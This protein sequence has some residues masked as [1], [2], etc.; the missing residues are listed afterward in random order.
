[1]ST[2]FFRRIGP[3]E[4][5]H[6]IGRGGMGHVFLAR[7]TRED[8]RVVALKV[9]PDGPDEEAGHR[10]A[11]ERQ[12]AELQRAFLQ[13]S[14]FVPR[15][16]EVDDADGYLYIAMEYVEGEDLSTVIRRGPME[17]RRAAAIAIQLCQFLEEIDRLDSST[18]ASPLTLLHNDL[19]P[20]NVRLTANDGVK[21]LD[22]GAAKSLTMSRR[23][24]RNDF[25]STPYL[26]PECLE[27]GDRDRQADAWAVGAILYEMVAGR[28]AF[29]ADST[30][31]L[32]DLI[33]SRT[34]PAAP[35]G[36]PTSLQA[37]IAKLLAPSPRDRYDGATAIREDLERFMSGLP[38]TAEEQ[39]GPQAEEDEPPTR[40]ISDSA[41]REN[42]EPA[43]RR[44]PRAAPSGAVTS[45]ATPPLPPEATTAPA[46][47]ERPG[48]A[49]SRRRWV[50][51]TLFFILLALVINEG[52]LSARAERLAATVPTQEFASLTTVWSEYDG[53]ARRSWFN[54]A[55]ARGLE[56]ALVDQTQ[57]LADRVIDSY[58]M[59]ASTVW[60]KQ[61]SEAEAA[62]LRATKAAPGDEH[63]R[64]TLRYVQGHLHRIDGETRKRERQDAQADRE[65]ARAVTAFREAARLRRNW[66]DPFL[67]LARAFIYG[68]GDMDRGADALRQ[69]ERL[70]HKLGPR[71]TAQLAY[72]YG[73]RGGTYEQTASKLAD[74]PQERE[75][76]TRA[77][78][79]YRRALD[80]YLDIATFGDVPTQMRLIQRRLERVERK[81]NEVDEARDE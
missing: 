9:V 3:Y 46:P 62:L 42:D 71:E 37:V 32:E 61:W 57:V 23:A 34:P 11:A 53:L 29:R 67:G 56:V 25:Y 65:L 76:L 64:G 16:Y 31:R 39:G 66:P 1:M 77:R 55:G 38:T 36:T 8:G 68:V 28:P 50:R 44:I 72:G 63:L 35:D 81:L 6:P 75:Y 78:D 30:R 10:A 26:S 17:P 33:R 45:V 2:T 73:V 4:I 80:L 21:V 24:T 70:G 13:A 60:S 52:C 69:A 18:D 79:D 74:M 48:K 41:T 14:P 22:F 47:Q 15:V 7:D 5:Q 49:R 59:S 27:T 43:T 19:K 58:R 54:G 20:T 40:R 51:R 12:G